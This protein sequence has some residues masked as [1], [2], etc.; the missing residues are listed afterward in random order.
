MEI[1]EK[2]EKKY[3]SLTQ[4]ERDFLWWN[5]LAAISF[6]MNAKKATEEANKRFGRNTLHNG[7]GDAFRHCYWSAMNARDAGI[8]KARAF[9]EAHE[10]WLGNPEGEKKMDLH[11]NEVGFDIGGKA[12]GASDRYLAVMCVQAWASGK[13]LQLKA[14]SD[15]DLV[16]SNAYENKVYK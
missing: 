4:A 8:K 5:P 16:Y 13:L 12:P 14:A 6:N 15:S 3:E 1:V 10:D 11:N 9:G 7:S 2:Y